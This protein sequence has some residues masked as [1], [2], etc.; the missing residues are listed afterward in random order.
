MIGHDPRITVTEVR[1]HDKP[2]RHRFRPLP[3][4]TVNHFSIEAPLHLP[5]R[6]LDRK[7]V[8]R[9]AHVFA[10]LHRR[11]MVAPRVIVML[12]GNRV[13]AFVAVRVKPE[14]HLV[15]FPI[16]GRVTSG[17]IGIRP[18][19]AGAARGADLVRRASFERVRAVELRLL[20]LHVVGRHLGAFACR[21][22]ERPRH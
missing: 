6:H 5:L 14:I 20:S 19:V 21:R 22:I 8:E 3:L 17:E 1:P 2:R 15:P 9:R 16:V 13:A 7:R 11:F 10:D 4:R 18:V 12:A